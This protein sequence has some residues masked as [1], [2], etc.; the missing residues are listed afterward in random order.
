M[1]EKQYVIFKL[2]EEEYGKHYTYPGNKEY[3]NAQRYRMH[4]I[5]LRDY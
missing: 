4:R 1:S 3:I 5:L 2:G